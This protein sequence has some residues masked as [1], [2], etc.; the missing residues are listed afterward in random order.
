MFKA[1]SHVIKRIE[2]LQCRFLWAGDLQRDKI[3]WIAWDLVKSPRANGGLGVQDLKILNTALLGKWAWRFA[4]ERNAW[5]RTLLVVKCGLGR[6]DWQSS[7]NEGPAG[8]SI[9]KGIVSFNPVFWRHGFLDPGGGLCDFWSDYWIRG[10]R[11]CEAYPRIA[12]AAQSL[13]SYVFDICSFDSGWK[14]NIPLTT[15]LRGGAL[16]EW[17]HLI[18][19]LEALLAHHITVG[20]ASVVW[21]LECSGLFS[22]RSLRNSLLAE[23]SSVFL[24]F[25]TNVIWSKA[26]PTKIQSFT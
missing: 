15:S 17:T 18:D 16:A 21:P 10:V 1:P 24:E 9:W 14:W 20:P 19:R 22:V 6:S 2:S 4:T 5:W 26:V 8:C 13:E 25:P 3:H 12:A 7:W 23:R 11:L